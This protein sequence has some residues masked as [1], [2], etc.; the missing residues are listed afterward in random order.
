MAKYAPG[1]KPTNLTLV[2]A[3]IAQAMANILQ[4]DWPGPHP[5]EVPR[6]GRVH[7]VKW[8]W[9]AYLVPVSMSPTDHRPNEVEIYVRA[10]VDRSTN[11]PTFTWQPFG[12]PYG[13]ESTKEC[14]KESE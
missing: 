8:Q 13:F 14:P 10:T 12:E 9:L 3:T 4:A 7:S 11:P 2:G 1:V 6:C 5:R